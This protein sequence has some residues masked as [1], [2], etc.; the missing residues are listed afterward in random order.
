MSELCY[1]CE[2]ELD[3]KDVEA[4]SNSHYACWAAED[5]YLE[6]VAHMREREQEAE[7]E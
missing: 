4:G 7:E 3:E 5:T 1:I 6:H 2:Q